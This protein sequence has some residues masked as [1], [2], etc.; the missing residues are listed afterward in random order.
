ML[1]AIY[2]KFLCKKL[3][4][5]DNFSHYILKFLINALYDENRLQMCSQV[6]TCLSHQFRMFSSCLRL[7]HF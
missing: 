4:L 7:S 6:D 3:F 5:I 2:L 1:Y